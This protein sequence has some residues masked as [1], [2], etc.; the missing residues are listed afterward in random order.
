MNPLLEKDISVDKEDKP[1][2]LA[3]LFWNDVK[4][5]EYNV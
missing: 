3:I 1:A 4:Q 2:D 5:V